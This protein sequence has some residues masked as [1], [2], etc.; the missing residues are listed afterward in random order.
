MMTA[1]FPYC[2]T[3]MDESIV[4]TLLVPISSD[5]LA[6]NEVSWLGTSL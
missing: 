3:A 6:S 5:F 4:A 1:L 2:I